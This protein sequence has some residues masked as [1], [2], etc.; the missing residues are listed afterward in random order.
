MGY[1]KPISVEKKDIKVGNQYYTCAYGGTIRVMVIK[2]FDDTNSV[3]VKVKSK[4][5]SPFVRSVKYIFD[6]PEMAKFAGRNWES[7]NRKRKKRR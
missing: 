3:L 2:I 7:D 5:C 1:K 6:N 4:K